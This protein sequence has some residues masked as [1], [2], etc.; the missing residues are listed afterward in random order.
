[1]K[2]LTKEA[3]NIIQ[4]ELL[5]RFCSTEWIQIVLLITE[6]KISIEINEKN[7]LNRMW[8]RNG[9]GST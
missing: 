9:Y 3:K 5:S 6:L 4:F 2:K 7:H 1:M 8:Y